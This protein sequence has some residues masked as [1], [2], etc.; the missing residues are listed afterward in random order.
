MSALEA[1]RLG[2]EI[3][4]TSAMKGLLVGLAV[5]FLVTG[6]ILLAAGATVAT[7]GAAAVVIGGLIAGTAGGG[8]AGMKIG[9][10][11][12]SDPKGPISTGSPNTFLGTGM[13]KAAR[14]TI[15]KVACEDHDDKLIAQG[16]VDVFINQAP[17]AR[18]T[19][20]TEC[21]GPIREGQPDVFFGGPTGTYLDMEPEVP[22]WLVTTLQVAMWV[23]AAIATGGAILTVGLGAALGGIAGGFAGGWVGGKLGG[24]I[25]GI[26]GEKGRVIGETAGSFLGS[27]VGGAFGA[28]G[29]GALEARLPQAT[30]ARMPGATP[31]HIQARQNVAREYYTKSPDF[32]GR[33]AADIDSHMSGIDFTR[34]VAVRTI[35]RPTVFGQYQ[36]PGGPRGNYIAGQN[37]PADRLGIGP[38]GY[39]RGTS[40][41]APKVIQNYEV[42]AG[43]QVLV[44]RSSPKIDT[45]STKSPTGAPVAQ[46]SGGGGQQIMIGNSGSMRPVGG[47]VPASPGLL[48]PGRTTL[49][50]GSS[51]GL[52]VRGDG[53]FTPPSIP[54]GG[55]GTGFG[56]GLLDGGP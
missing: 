26:F 40:T 17:A 53:A 41:A 44:S 11:F 45:W 49:P 15:D 3:G 47:Q 8:L 48:Q 20:K 42:P 39:N 16:S 6:A 24:A 38:M 22:G 56:G 25:G 54:A 27:M 29:G 18:R 5:G 36:H 2:D 21:S 12:E 23:G 7:G 51:G 52:P 32:A 10:M 14:A 4:H 50:G 33:S 31:A 1:A 55:V 35:D 46:H 30:L 19:D 34:P 37:T 28:K 43:T 13:R 9:S